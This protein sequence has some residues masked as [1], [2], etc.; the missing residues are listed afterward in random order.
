MSDPHTHPCAHCRT[1]VD[2]HGARVPNFDGW[3]TTVCVSYHLYG[4]IAN[5]AF[6][7]ED[8]GDQARAQQAI[9]R[10]EHAS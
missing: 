2:C 3:P 9:D 1:P 7:C 5:P 10:A 4:G 6:I 8:C